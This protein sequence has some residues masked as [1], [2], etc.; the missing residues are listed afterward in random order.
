MCLLRSE[1]AARSRGAGNGSAE[2]EGSRLRNESPNARKAQL[3][4]RLHAEQSRCTR[5]S[6]QLPVL[7]IRAPLKNIINLP[8]AKAAEKRRD[9]THKAGR[10]EA[11]PATLLRLGEKKTPQVLRDGSV[12]SLPHI[13]Q[14]KPVPSAPP[15]CWGQRGPPV[16][17]IRTPR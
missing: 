17:L 11:P 3:L 1:P 8:L 10:E 4:G 5:S 2:G 13:P 6:L 14:H 9:Q 7:R 12:G 16:T 15:S